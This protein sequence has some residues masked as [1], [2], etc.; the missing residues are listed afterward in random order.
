MLF[1][2]IVMMYACELWSLMEC[3]FSTDHWNFVKS[4]II[5][6][7]IITRYLDTNHTTI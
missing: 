5:H 1:K 6:Q 7:L 3:I 2:K 4:K